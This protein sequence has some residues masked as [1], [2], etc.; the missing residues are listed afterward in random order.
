MYQ[1]CVVVKG[2]ATYQRLP[3]DIRQE[4]QG[5]VQK[6]SYFYFYYGSRSLCDTT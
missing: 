1:K 6:I 5:S 3:F 2:H 4:T